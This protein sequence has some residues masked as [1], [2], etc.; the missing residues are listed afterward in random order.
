MEHNNHHVPFPTVTTQTIEALYQAEQAKK[1]RRMLL[2]TDDYDE[3]GNVIPPISHREHAQIHQSLLPF[4]INDITKFNG[5]Q[6]SISF[7][8]HVECSFNPN[9]GTCNF[10]KRLGCYHTIYARKW[11]MH[12]QATCELLTRNP[13]SKPTSRL[14]LPK[15]YVE[16]IIIH[17]NQQQSQ[18][19][20]GLSQLDVP[21]DH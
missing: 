16:A 14:S 10:G 6:N 5:P 21:F 1:L 8:G 17:Y 3:H 4:T 13:A 9:N 18:S 7:T 15:E 20:R 2:Q 19:S 12:N 11:P